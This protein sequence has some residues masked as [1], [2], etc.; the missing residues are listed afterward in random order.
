MDF[1]KVSAIIA[2]IIG[3]STITNLFFKWVVPRHE[4]ST[5]I[6]DIKRSISSVEKEL[7]E[8]LTR[9]S[10]NEEINRLELV[11]M[12]GTLS[13]LEQ[14]R[15]NQEHDVLQSYLLCVQDQEYKAALRYFELNKR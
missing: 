9:K 12:E 6:A 7:P 1:K 10:F 15:C 2:L 11:M 8:L 13:R 14:S 5:E 3:C 4:F